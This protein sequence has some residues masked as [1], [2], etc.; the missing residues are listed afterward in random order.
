VAD[1]FETREIPQIRKVAALL[2]FHRLHNAVLS[3]Q[4]HTLVIGFFL[5]NQ[6]PPVVPQARKLLNKIMLVHLHEDGETYDFVVRQAHLPRPPAAGGAAL[7]FVK[8]RHAECLIS[9]YGQANALFA[10]L[11]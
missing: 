1:F 9:I 6:P 2:W 11:T 4:K 3:V 7:A 8:N 5:Q 10:I